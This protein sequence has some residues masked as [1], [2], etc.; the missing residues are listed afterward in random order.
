MTTTTREGILA[1]HAL[2][3]C[4]ALQLPPLRARTHGDAVAALRDRRALLL[5]H[6]AHLTFLA[7]VF[8]DVTEVVNILTADATAALA[9]ADRC[10]PRR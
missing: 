9:Q 10:L 2:T 5:D 8:A 4:V 3:D 6:A 1:A 7:S